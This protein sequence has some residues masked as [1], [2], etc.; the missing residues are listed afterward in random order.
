MNHIGFMIALNRPTLSDWFGAVVRHYGLGGS[1]SLLGSYGPFE[2]KKLCRA[3]LL[4]IP[5]ERAS[6]ADGRF[7]YYIILIGMTVVNRIS[8]R[9]ALF[10]E[11]NMPGTSPEH[12]KPVELACMRGHDVDDH[13]AIIDNRP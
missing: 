5:I 7:Q 13:P 1:P 4:C 3:L 2:N 9:R 8:L 12:F 6:R 11:R 10:L